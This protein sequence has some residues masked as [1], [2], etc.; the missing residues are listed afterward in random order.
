MRT[1]AARKA[2]RRAFTLIEVMI[3]IVIVLALGGLVAY[4]LLNKKEQADDKMVQIQMNTI[5]QA[6]KDF[7]FTH[8]RYPT[9]EEGIAV[10]WNK[11]A[12]SDEDVLKK[13]TK[14]LEKP[15]PEDL[16]G[17]QWGYR[18]KSEHSEEDTYDLWSYGRDKQEGTE[19]DIV[20]WEKD[21]ESGGT[22]PSGTGGTGG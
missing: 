19:D 22:G 6:L 12:T 14:L 10:L 3:V 20:S 7:R 1:G 5:G 15:V 18:Q 21:A 17:N 9:D 4:N 13:W 2:W 8:N 11:D 16:Y